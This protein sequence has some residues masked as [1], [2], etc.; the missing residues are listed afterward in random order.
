MRTTGLDA[1]IQALTQLATKA[2]EVAAKALYKGA[3]IMADEY[4]RAVNGMPTEKNRFVKPGDP[5][6]HATEAEKNAVARAIGIA[7]YRN[8]DDDVNT[9]I[10]IGTGGY[11]TN[12]RTKKYPNGKPIP[13]IANGINSGS[14]FIIKY[15]F[16]RQAEAAGKAK[17][18]AAVEAEANRLIE[19]LTNNG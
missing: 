18:L 14:S 5:P 3:G 2:S 17:A 16:A 12:I 10:G 6:R 4:K 13:L 19:E 7:R 9:S 15:P 11:A 1:E 8:T